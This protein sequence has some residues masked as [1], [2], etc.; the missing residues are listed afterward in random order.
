MELETRAAKFEIRAMDATKGSFT[1]YASLIENIIPGSNIGAPWDEV[2]KAGAFTKTIKESGGKNPILAVHDRGKWL[3][4]STGATEDKVGL[5]IDAEL[6]INDVQESREQ[7]AL[8]Q[9]AHKLNRPAGL[10]IS[11]RPVQELWD[12]DLNQRQILELDW[13]ETS[14]LPTGFAANPGSDV[15]S[16]RSTLPFKGLTLAPMDTAWHAE[17]ARERVQEFAQWEGRLSKQSFSQAFIWQ[18]RSAITEDGY[19]LQIADVIEGELRAV[20]RAI[21][22]AAAILQAGKHSKPNTDV[23][24]ARLH[25]GKYYERM[26]LTAPWD[27]RIIE[28]TYLI[29]G[30]AL[31]RIA[32]IDDDLA[33]ELHRA[34]QAA[35]TS[36]AMK[37]IEEIL[38][39]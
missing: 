2:V 7:F 39:G 12:D 6:L 36:E 26:E 5:L 30:D 29:G 3:G 34:D 37:L 24:R 15:V 13:K 25:L 20:P 14:V 22:H 32:D 16:L 27:V 17:A 4:S 33:L 28:P 9:Q 38:H 11:F 21:F 1:G 8:M 31:K 23:S 19:S 10:S 35:M 18:D